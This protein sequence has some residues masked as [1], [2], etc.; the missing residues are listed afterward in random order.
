MTGVYKITSPSKKIYIGSSANIEKRIKYYN[1]VSCKKQTKLYNSIKE[2]GWINHNLEILI[3]CKVNELLSLER[4]Y[5]NLYNVLS[6]NGLNSILPK[7]NE[8]EIGISEDT[9]I[10]MSNSKLGSKNF[11]FGKTHSQETKNIISK[12]HKGRK[13]TMEHRAKV[14][15]NN[16]RGMSKNVLDLNMGIFYNSAKEVSKTFNIPHSTLKSRLNGSL[17]NATQFIYC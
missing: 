14:S 6:D 8:I 1:S 10:K 17:K 4:Y 3:E 11:F 2:Y 7:N 15:K 13:H 9:R 12:I 16:G 5:G